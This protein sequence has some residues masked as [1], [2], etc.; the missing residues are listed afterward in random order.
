[1]GRALGSG[2]KRMTSSMQ[3]SKPG[4]PVVVAA[5]FGVM[6]G[7]GS[8]VVFTFSVF[9]SPISAEC[10]W[11]REAVSTAFGLAAV[12]VALASPK[13]GQLLDRLGP[14]RIILPCYIVYGLALC[15][16]A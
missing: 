13:L 11:S 6:A 4:W 10:G 3:K 15:S 16:L 1:M 5:F 12:S 9:L 2:G 8:L 14:R 7:F